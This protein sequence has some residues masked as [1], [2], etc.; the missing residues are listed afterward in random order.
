MDKCVINSASHGS[1][2]E[3]RSS[4]TPLPSSAAWLRLFRLPTPTSCATTGFSRTAPASETS[5]LRHQQPRTK[6]H[7][8][9]KARPSP[10]RKRLTTTAVL[11]L[12]SVLVASHGRILCAASWLDI[13]V[14]T[15]PKCAASMVIIAFLTDPSVLTRILDHLKLP[16]SS[17]PLAPARSRIDE[18][19]LFAEE[20]PS[21]PAYQVSIHKLPSAPKPA[22]SPAA[23]F[24]APKSSST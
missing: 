21:E 22:P 1:T 18:Q 6:K 19:D 13:D 4:S 11:H 9:S 14:L 2:G 15:C 16:S 5:Y 24:I 12:Q 8:S 17:P 20:E 23:S 3:P 10:A 7:R